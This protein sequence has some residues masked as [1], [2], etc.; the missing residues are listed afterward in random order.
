MLNSFISLYYYLM[1]VRQMYQFDPVAGM[2]RFKV[3]P[4]TWVLGAGLMLGVLFIGIYPG[5]AFK[6]AENAARP[7]FQQQ[8]EASG[9]ARAP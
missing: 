7:L 9:A 2:V 5:P 4:V 6:A 1:I 3:S 8:A